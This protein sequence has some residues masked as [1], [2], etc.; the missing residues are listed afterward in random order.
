MK[1]KNI[2]SPCD[3]S[4]EGVDLI[5]VIPKNS[6][7]G[8]EL[9]REGFISKIHATDQFAEVAT[10]SESKYTTDRAG[11]DFTN[12]I[13]TFVNVLT[14]DATWGL[15]HVERLKLNVVFRT[16]SGRFFFIGDRMGASLSFKPQTSPQGYAVTIKDVSRFPILEVD[17][18]AIDLSAGRAVFNFD[19]INNATCE[20]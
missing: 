20:V 8:F 2:K 5:L 9:L 11:R 3:Y 17:P 6:V 18:S 1:V 14:G 16:L 10:T 12:T 15:L 13:E 7:A 4:P 19:Y